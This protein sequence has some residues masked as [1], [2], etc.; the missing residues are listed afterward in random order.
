MTATINHKTAVWTIVVLAVFAAGVGVADDKKL[1]RYGDP[2]PNDDVIARLGTVRFRHMDVVQRSY[3]SPDDKVMLTQAYSG[4]V[5]L[6][7]AKTGKWLAELK[8]TPRGYADAGVFSP[9]GKRFITCGR[10]GNLYVRSTKSGRIIA[11]W[12]NGKAGPHAGLN[13]VAVSPN[14]KLIAVPDRNGKVHILNASARKIR[15][16]ACFTDPPNAQEGPPPQ[17]QPRPRPRRGQGQGQGGGRG[18]EVKIPVLRIVGGVAFSPDGSLLATC[19]GDGIVRIFKTA[20]WTLVRKIDRNNEHG[21]PGLSIVRFLPDGSRIA[22][23]EDGSRIATADPATGKIG[24][25][26]DPSRLI[27]FYAISPDGKSI[28]AIGKGGQF[29]AWDIATGTVRFDTLPPDEAIKRT[30]ELLGFLAQMFSYTIVYSPD[31]KK[32]ITS[33]GGFARIGANAPK[34]F[35]ALTGKE[36]NPF[37]EAH[38]WLVSRVRYSTDSKRIVSKAMSGEIAEWDIDTMKRVSVIPADP[39]K[40]HPICTSPNRKLCA[41]NVRGG[42][43]V[44]EAATGKERFTHPFDA[45]SKH[46]VGIAFSPDG[47]L[48]AISLKK[49]RIKD[50]KF[51]VMRTSD[52][53]VL[54]TSGKFIGHKQAL[55]FS[56]NSRFLA[57]S[58]RGGPGTRGRAI[59]L[60]DMKFGGAELIRMDG[61]R[62]GVIHN[63][64][65][66]PD[67][68]LMV[69]TFGSGKIR[70]WDMITGGRIKELTGQSNSIYGLAFSRDSR[71]LV[72]GAWDRTVRVWDLPTGKELACFKGHKSPVDC[73]DY[74]PDGKS[75]AAGGWDTTVLVWS[76]AKVNAK[77]TTSLPPDDRTAAK[78]WADANSDDAPTAY[79]AACA[80]ATRGEEAIATI[81]ADIKPAL[82]L[83]GIT[84]TFAA[85][86]V[87]LDSDSF[88]IRMTAKNK[89]I[90]LGHG[91]VEYILQA[92]KTEKLSPEVESLLEE[93]ISK[94]GGSWYSSVIIRRHRRAVQVLEM[95]GS[96]QAIAALAVLAEGS[97][98]RTLTLEAKAALRRLRAP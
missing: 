33:G 46:L 35:D 34:F 9:D 56:A 13:D 70:I 29:L 27:C 26:L 85:A 75:I 6:W 97:T 25:I 1:D 60:F 81:T 53:K 66:S 51:T 18:A 67:G 5:T 16:L 62:G 47:K 55:C 88:A 64:R 78:L 87:E 12:R 59:Y 69:V 36:A 38:D 14:G 40:P 20:N 58:G 39:E 3:F 7:D 90:I 21:A 80:L 28:A 95:I 50:I 44:T 32:V 71:R 92:L 65:F 57:A 82:E 89:I 86:L 98:T 43:L 42:V 10:G 83:K 24:R 22:W 37:K 77:L 48:F 8:R 41:Y 4:L 72:S 11:S 74:A 79:H 68:K 63:M 52:G 93:C 84:A 19:G 17:P 73:V 61:H 45:T 30:K 76:L 94:I 49:K 91:A 96:K 31:S 54:M 23:M 2:L 15:S